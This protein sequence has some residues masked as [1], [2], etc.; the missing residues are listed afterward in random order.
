MFFLAVVI[1]LIL[2]VLFELAYYDSSYLNRNA[3]TFS[4]NN[5]NSI[6]TKNFIRYY[7]NLYRTI[8]VKIFKDHK[9]YWEPEAGSLRADLPEIKIISK[10]K[11]NFLP[12]R[13]IEN[14]EKNFS[15]WPRSHG[16][17]S[18]MRFSSLS[19]INKDN[20][21]NLKLAWIFNSKDGKKGIEANPV[22]YEG[23]VYV[24]TPGNHIICLNGTNGKEYGDIK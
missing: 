16:G 7:D 12:G 11:D 22:V 23:L 4:T 24:P 19:L 18:S 15:N 21:N 17:F 1:L 13:K 8:S 9:K 3:L 20:I 14:V 5:L 2:L 6:K 10:K